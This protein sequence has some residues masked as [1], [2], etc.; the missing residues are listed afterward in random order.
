MIEYTTD[1]FLRAAAVM[2]SC[3]IEPKCIFLTEELIGDQKTPKAKMKFDVDENVVMT[4]NSREMSVE[5]I[6]YGLTLRRL[7]NQ[8]FKIIEKNK[9]LINE[10]KNQNPQN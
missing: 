7:K 6:A 10:S 9:E 3:H 8:V 1:D 4:L 2:T 5:P